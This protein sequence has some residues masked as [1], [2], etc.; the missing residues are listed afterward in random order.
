MGDTTELR[1][2]VIDRGPA[3]R[4][5]N[6]IRHVGGAWN[7]QQVTAGHDSGCVNRG[8]EGSIAF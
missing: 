8:N 5:K 3:D 7:L 6:A 2:T 4:L 1:P